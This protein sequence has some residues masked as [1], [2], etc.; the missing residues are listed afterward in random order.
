MVPETRAVF[1]LLTNRV[2]PRVGTIDMREIRRHFNSLAVE[3]IRES[4]TEN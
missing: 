3:T 4:V 1:V 2:H